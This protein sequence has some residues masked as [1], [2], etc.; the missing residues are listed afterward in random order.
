MRAHA[1]T[2]LVTL[3]LFSAGCPSSGSTAETQSE[4]LFKAKA[5]LTGPDR[6]SV[7]VKEIRVEAMGNAPVQH[8]GDELLFLISE[9]TDDNVV[10]PLKEITSIE[11]LKPSEPTKR[12][13]LFPVKLTLRSG[14]SRNLILF[15]FKE[16]RGRT[17]DEGAPFRRT[18]ETISRIDFLNDPS[19][20]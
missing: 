1:L 9:G 13:S 7:S 18:L 11:L 6:Q 5:V 14:D 2:L 20:D 19:R 17:L 16:M 3:T 10:Y 12:H 4:E 15:R 8:R